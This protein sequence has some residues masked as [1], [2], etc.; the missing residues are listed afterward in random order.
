M[1]LINNKFQ[2]QGSAMFKVRLLLCPHVDAWTINVMFNR[3]DPAE[4]DE[5]DVESSRFAISYEIH[6][7]DH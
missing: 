7:Y 5:N 2:L 6:Q 1:T 3:L 4:L